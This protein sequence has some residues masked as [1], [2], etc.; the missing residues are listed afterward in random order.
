MK[1]KCII[2]EDMPSASENLQIQLSEFDNIDIIGTAENYT[3]AIEIVNRLKPDLI[4]CDLQ[5][6]NRLGFEILDEC[7][8]NYEYVVFI[9]AYDNYAL[10]AHEYDTISYLLKPIEQSKLEIAIS[11]VSSNLSKTQ[12]ENNATSIISNNNSVSLKVK[13]KKLF[14]YSDQSF[15]AVN[16]EN[17]LYLEADT[18]STIIVTNDNKYKISKRLAY[19]ENILLAHDNFVRI[20][21]SY[22]VNA[23]KII[24]ASKGL[25]P[26][27][28]LENNLEIPIS[29]LQK[30]NIFIQLGI[31][32]E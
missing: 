25:K 10:K 7:M 18:S 29:I 30:S 14:V 11:K 31:N 16:I 3:Q 1:I 13:N 15:Q 28:T 2:I 32:L 21:K 27:I 6:G 24:K 12:N 8:G 26:S 20:H 9:T 17:I 4:F 5:I 23:D 19:Y 22:I